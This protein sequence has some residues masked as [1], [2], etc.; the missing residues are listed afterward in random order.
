MRQLILICSAAL[1]LT[2]CQPQPTVNSNAD[3]GAITNNEVANV[4]NCGIAANTLADEKTLFAA[5]TAYNVAA[6]AYVNF[7]SQG[8]LPASLK[9]AVR[10]KLISAY[11]YLKLARGA[12]NASNGCQL[13]QYVELVKSLA[14]QARSLMPTQ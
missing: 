7:D 1:A 3:T 8:K 6:N 10:P 4:T 12:Y 13:N 14:G 11:G 9:A 5:E 2:A